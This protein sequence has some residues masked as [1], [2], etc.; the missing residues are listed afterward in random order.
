[1]KTKTIR[2]SVNFKCAAADVYNALMNSKTHSL[3]TGSKALISKKTGGKFSA[4]DGYATGNNLE[5]IPNQKIVQSWHASDWP[6]NAISTVSFLIT[7]TRTGCKLTFIQT[8][9]PEQFFN[10]VAEG[11]KE[12]Y[13]LP[14]QQ[15]LNH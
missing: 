11:W 14:M 5:L 9:V 7:E 15:L 6:V 10:S 2:Q 12:Y 1:M 3:F 4:Y 13:W 8:E